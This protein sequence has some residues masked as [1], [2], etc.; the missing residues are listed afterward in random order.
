M[1]G[2]AEIV[3]L[4]KFDKSKENLHAQGGKK[5]ADSDDDE[6]EEEGRGHGQRVECGN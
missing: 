6:E 5:A 4:K 3:F 2:D 1:N